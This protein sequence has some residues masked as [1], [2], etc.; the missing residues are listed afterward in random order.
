MRLATLSVGG[1]PSAVVELGNG[2]WLVV[3]QAAGASNSDALKAGSLQAIIEAGDDAAP[4]LRELVSQ[5][6]AGQHAGAVVTD[7]QLMAPIPQPR[8]N[9]F[10]VGR[11]YAEH[12]AEGDRAQ[13]QKVGVTEHPVF[14]TKPP[15][16]IVAPGGDILLFPDVSTSIDYEVELAVIIG[17]PGRNITRRDAYDHIF[18]YTIL[19]DVTARD[20]QRR[21]GGQY[22]K[23]KGLDGSCPVGPWIVTADEISDPHKLSIGLTVNGE[24]RQDGTTADMIF[25]IPTLI[26][27]LSEGLTLEPGDIIATGTPSGVGYAMD[28]PRF[29]A[30]GD[31]VVCTVSEIGELS[32]SVRVA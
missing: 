25:D 26:A 29:L 19:N 4:A 8:K 13:N 20:V 3:A 7:P 1:K 10:C 21:H 22:F 6:E 17:Q 24:Q 9:V 5:A 14:F 18:G 27:S 12:I 11:N 16:S 2:S 28:P 23:G 32:N 15:T 31:T 30:A